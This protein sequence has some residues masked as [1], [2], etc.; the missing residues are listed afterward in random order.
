MIDI[1][2]IELI[3]ESAPKLLGS[4]APTLLQYAYN[5]IE[6]LYKNYGKKELQ[7]IDDIRDCYHFSCELLEKDG[8]GGVPTTFRLELGQN[9]EKN[10]D[11]PFYLQMDSINEKQPLYF[12][13]K[14]VCIKESERWIN[15][16]PDSSLANIIKDMLARICNY[17][18]MR[19]G[20]IFGQGYNYDP[21]TLFFEEFK[22]WLLE[23]SKTKYTDKTLDAVAAR[24]EYLRAIDIK[25]VFKQSRNDMTRHQTVI[26]LL[27]CF[28]RKIYPM[29]V[30]KI[31]QSG[32]QEQFSQLADKTDDTYRS[33]SQFLF[34]VVREGENV[35]PNFDWEGVKDL[36]RE[37]KPLVDGTVSGQLLHRVLN[38]FV[39]NLEQNDEQ[40][41]FQKFKWC[42]YNEK[43]E[44]I[45]PGKK[46]ETGEWYN[47]PLKGKKLG[48]LKAFQEKKHME[49][50]L[51]L[52]GL[53]E[54]LFLFKTIVKSLHSLAIDGGNLL[55]Y[56]CAMY[57]VRQALSD[58]RSLLDE[59]FKNLTL[60]H[61][62]VNTHRRQL[63]EE[64]RSLTSE[65][66][67][68]KE[69]FVLAD[70]AFLKLTRHRT[71]VLQESKNL[72]S[73]IE[74]KIDE[75]NSPAYVQQ[76]K[77]KLHQFV[78]LMTLFTDKKLPEV[79]KIGF[80]EENKNKEQEISLEFQVKPKE[81]GILLPMGK[82]NKKQFSAEI[83][84]QTV[85]FQRVEI[86]TGAESIFQIFQQTR[87]EAIKE[88]IELCKKDT[89]CQHL[90]MS[91][92]YM[93]F[94]KKM[95]F[96]EAYLTLECCRI[97][98][99]LLENKN[100][101]EKEHLN[102]LDN[103]AG[104]KDFIIL[105]LE[106][107]YLVE[108]C[109]VRYWQGV[110]GIVSA[111]AYANGKNLLILGKTL[112]APLGVIAKLPCKNAQDS[113]N[114]YLWLQSTLGQ[115]EE[116]GYS[117]FTPLIM[118]NHALSKSSWLSSK[119]FYEM[120]TET[121][122][123]LATEAEKKRE[124]TEAVRCL[125]ILIERDPGNILC[126]KQRAFNLAST[127]EHKKRQLALQD[128]NLALEHIEEKIRKNNNRMFNDPGLMEL[129]IDVLFQRGLTYYYMNDENKINLAIDDF[130]TVIKLKNDCFD[131]FYQ[132]GTIFLDNQNLENALENALNYFNEAINI[133]PKHEDALYKRCN[134]FFYLGKYEEAVK[135]AGALCQLFP[136]NQ[137][138]QFKLKQLQQKLSDSSHEV[139]NNTVRD[140]KSCL[141]N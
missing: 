52:H 50:F 107:H 113:S 116:L 115:D 141:L 57:A 84:E 19:D 120:E 68:W 100:A 25:E 8:G 128:F 4:I 82:I 81:R 22:T 137:D 66:K 108:K 15:A 131:A 64:N 73:K 27:K 130:R 139:S 78:Y 80:I 63:V 45:Y 97:Y 134:C 2:P 123:K 76:V 39:A 95:P 46:P 3:K 106:Q 21:T 121:L 18:Q 129:K 103:C 41:S 140:N 92:I 117:Q 9:D 111:L 7:E 32:A 99:N 77:Q 88:L 105:Y 43:R 48:I 136:E 23:L 1:K 54:K 112:D 74:T 114:C 135:D 86:Q 6:A 118:L 38:S 109:G 20:R 119:D 87:E 70:Q 60:L 14:L 67:H 13:R 59:L 28:E 36:E 94:G 102:A 47:T 138:Y 79:P 37:Y 126:L 33:L 65:E 93:V 110:T 62:D 51:Q 17:Q 98:N 24:M 85:N 5:K 72:L 133:Q 83:E 34:H 11:Y 26:K 124:H 89:H 55:V 44:L 10:R 31:L 42:C 71:G 104:N 132:L 122:F 29:L 49:V 96:P 16:V 91:E 30:G 90:V 69:S 35:P 40:S 101:K 125:N 53:L 127:G 58:Y 75:V 61:S 12:T 56:G